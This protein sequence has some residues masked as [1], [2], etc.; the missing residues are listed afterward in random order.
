MVQ[1]IFL[2]RN[3]VQL[4]HF[5]GKGEIYNFIGEM[6]KCLIYFCW[7]FLTSTDLFSSSSSSCPVSDGSFL[8]TLASSLIDFNELSSVAAL[9]MLLE[10]G[11]FV[12]VFFLPRAETSIQQEELLP[13][14]SD[15]EL[16]LRQKPDYNNK[17]YEH[18]GKTCLYSSAPL[19]FIVTV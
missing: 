3:T 4:Q 11:F 18:S 5:C 7:N 9:N 13:K 17:S 2:I 6:L 1:N 8:R 10:V 19:Q 12:V 14:L 15:L 16:H